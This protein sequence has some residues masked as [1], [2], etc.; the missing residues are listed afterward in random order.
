M[1]E[2]YT[3]SP[4]GRES[5]T[6]ARRRRRAISDIEPDVRDAEGLFLQPIRELLLPARVLDGGL[7]DVG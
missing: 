4:V 6:P 3:A 5:P 2:R 1:P 7:Q